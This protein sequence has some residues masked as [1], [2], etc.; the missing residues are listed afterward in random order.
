M[1]ALQLHTTIHARG[2]AAAILL[3]DEQVAALGSVKNPPVVVTIGDR[4]ARL[5]IARMGGENML[6]LSKAARAELGVEIG[7]DVEVEIALDA[8]ERTVE[9]PPALAEALAADPAA[10]AAFDAL[11]YSRRKEI[12]RSIAEAKQEATRD[13]RLEKALAELRG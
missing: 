5:R 8:A 3:S 1:N 2:L 10:K 7:D 12:A 6:G 13:R 9:V 4:V 11:A